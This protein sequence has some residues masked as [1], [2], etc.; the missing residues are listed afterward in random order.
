MQYKNFK[1]NQIST[2]GF[3]ALRMP[4]DPNGTNQFDRAEGQRI[5]DAVFDAGIN[6][7]DTAYTYIGGDSERFLGETL[8]AIPVTAII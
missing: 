6:Y 7:F 8:S 4:M 2:L 5:I 3:G 1:G